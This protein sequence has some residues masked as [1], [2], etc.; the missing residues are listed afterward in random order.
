MPRDNAAPASDKE[1]VCWV[2]YGIIL[3]VSISL[4][5]CS[6][7]TVDVNQ[8]GLKF[9]TLH[10]YYDENRVLFPGRYFVGIVS[11]IETFPT[12]WQSIQFCQ[13]CDDGGP[14]TG[15]AAKGRETNPVNVYLEVFIFYKLR[16]EQIPKL[17]LTFPRKDWHGRYVSISKNAIALSIQRFSVDDL[18]I[19]REKVGLEIGQIVN[20]RLAPVYGFV[21]SVYIG[22]VVLDKTQ[23]RAYLEQW[24]KR[25]DVNTSLI[26]GETEKIRQT[27]EAEVSV[28][29]AN[30]K[31]ILSTQ[32]MWG[33]TTFAKRKAIGDEKVLKAQG[34]GYKDL[35]DLLEFDNQELLKY[36]YYEKMRDNADSMVAG[37]NEHDKLLSTQ[38]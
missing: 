10:R 3:I 7:A 24:I 13:G 34:L 5:S 20:A 19:N 8:A 23:D 11:Q 38:R 4:F 29:E 9:N 31:T 21:T 36:I 33:N 12:T 16:V 26:N 25:R 15:K 30:V 18:L 27:T 14:V 28:R 17:I 35:R 6:F 37:F 22:Q 1:A 2:C 32:Y